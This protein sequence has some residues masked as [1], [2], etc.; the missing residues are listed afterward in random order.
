MW[1]FSPLHG[2]V[3][4]NSAYL[5]LQAARVGRTG[6]EGSER[7]DSRGESWTQQ[8]LHRAIK[9]SERLEKGLPAGSLCYCCRLAEAAVVTGSVRL[10]LVNI[11]IRRG[12]Y[13]HLVAAPAVH[14]RDEM[15]M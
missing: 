15:K 7:R 5:G 9:G 11:I 10:D 8:E 3:V 2:D 13:S 4:N 6:G 12:S 1:T 14:I